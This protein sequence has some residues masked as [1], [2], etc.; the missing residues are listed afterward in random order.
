MMRNLFNP[1]SS[2]LAIDLGTANTLVYAKGRGIV[3]SEPSIVAINKV[4]NK[5]EAVGKEAKEMLGRTPGNIIAIRPM[6]DGVI[7]DFEVTEKMLQHFIRKAHNGRS[8]VSPRVVIGVPGAWRRTDS[9]KELTQNAHLQRR[10]VQHL[11]VRGLDHVGQR[12]HHGAALAERAVGRHDRDRL[13]EALAFDRLEHPLEGFCPNDHVDPLVPCEQFLGQEVE[14]RGTVAF[15]HE[16]AVRVSLRVGECRAEGADH[17]EEL[18]RLHR[19]EPCRS[20]TSWI[21]DELQRAGPPTSP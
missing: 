20:G 3:V 1:F 17:F 15:R 21:D 11:R 9:G 2:D 12:I 14:R 5:V 6:K 19:R 8:W 7:A 10:R 13:R 18:M 4:T 16:Q